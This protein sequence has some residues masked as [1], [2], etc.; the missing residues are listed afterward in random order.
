MMDPERYFVVDGT[1]SVEEINSQITARVAELPALKRNA[2]GQQQSKFL[3]P[4]HNAT[5]AVTTTVT[6]AVKARKQVSRRKF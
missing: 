3:K 2:Q 4:I 5:H 6:R 1:Q